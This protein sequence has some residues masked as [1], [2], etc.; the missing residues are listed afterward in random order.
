MTAL[1][2]IKSQIE[3]A[4][5]QLAQTL[6][7]VSEDQVDFKPIPNLMSMREQV[8]HLCECYQAVKTHA[9]GGKHEWGKYSTG[10]TSWTGLLETFRT[11][12]EEAVEMA[13]ASDDAVS[14]LSE[15]VVAHDN[16]HVGQLVVV[17]TSFDA[18]WNSYSIYG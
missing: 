8:E 18:E 1:E 2:L 4:G 6:A 10:A 3:A 17:R 11:S 13:L 7:G 5:F 12:R 15:Y 16:Y 9:Q 14:V